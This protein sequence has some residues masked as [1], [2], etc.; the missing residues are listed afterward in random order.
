MLDTRFN[1]LVETYFSGW[2]VWLLHGFCRKQ[3][4]HFSAFKTFRYLVLRQLSYSLDML[5]EVSQAKKKGKRGGPY[6]ESQLFLQHWAY[7]LYG[8]LYMHGP[9]MQYRHFRASPAA[10]ATE[11]K[12]SSRLYTHGSHR[13]RKHASQRVLADFLYSIAQTFGGLSWG[14]KKIA[15]MLGVLLTFFLALHTFYMPT[16][17]FM[18]IHDPDKHIEPMNLQAVEYFFQYHLFTAALFLQSY[19]VFDICRAIAFLDDVHAP[20]DIVISYLRSSVSIHAHWNAFHASWRQFFLRYIVIQQKREISRDY[21]IELMVFM[22]SAY[23]HSDTMWYI[24]FFSNYLM[25]QG[26]KWLFKWKRFRDEEI[27]VRGIYQSIIFCVNLLFFPLLLIIELE[28]GDLRYSFEGMRYFFLLNVFFLLLNCQ[29]IK[30]NPDAF[31]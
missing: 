25:Y 26:E 15:G 6:S 9:C 28:K 18:K 11:S 24:Y 27:A 30:K 19:I 16:V 22:L 21:V 2:P 23:L 1:N 5:E 4:N 10:A 29:R 31:L 17:F 14:F 20:K 13:T 3:I 7:I 12:R 8:P